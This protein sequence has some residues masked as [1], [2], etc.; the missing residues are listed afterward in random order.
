MAE[1]PKL[2]ATPSA[3]EE[4][5]DDKELLEVTMSAEQLKQK[6]VENAKIEQ[7]RKL[8]E[9]QKAA[10]EAA[11]V[12]KAPTADDFPI[13][14]SS[15]PPVGKAGMMMGMNLPT[16]GSRKGAFEV[17]D[18]TRR[19]A[20]LAMMKLDDIIGMDEKKTDEADS[21]SMMDIMRAKNA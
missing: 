11:K 19:Q 14:S 8:R 5:A 21:R 3:F 18:E 4:D 12:N 17:D 16:I 7:M 15:L 9:D 20:K 2:V 1:Q 6:E 10:K 13:P